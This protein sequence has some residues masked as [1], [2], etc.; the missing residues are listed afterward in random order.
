MDFFCGSNPWID[1][2][3]RR[4]R[5]TRRDDRSPPEIYPEAPAGSMSSTLWHDVPCPLLSGRMNRMNTVM[6][7]KL[8]NHSALWPVF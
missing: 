2:A 7:V 1:V 6:L 8:A 5:R 4:N 3:P